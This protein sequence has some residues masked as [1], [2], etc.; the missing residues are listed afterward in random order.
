MLQRDILSPC[1]LL[2]RGLS[3]VESQKAAALSGAPNPTN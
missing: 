3:Y 1:S 2:K